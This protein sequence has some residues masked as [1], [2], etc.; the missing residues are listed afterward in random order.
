ML[1]AQGLSVAAASSGLTAYNAGGV[2]GVV[3]WAAL[4][5]M[6]GSRKPMVWGAIAGA[7][8]GVALI[9]LGIEAGGSHALLIA[10]VGLN[11]LFANAIQTTLFALAAHVYPT[12]C[13]L[14]ELPWP[15]RWGAWAA[16]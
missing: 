5:T 11:G 7:A 8:S 10:G 3:I 4:L 15:R 1:T 16:C 2:L 14:P 9:F 12:K 13:G 6:W